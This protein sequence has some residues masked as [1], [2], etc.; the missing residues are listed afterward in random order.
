M[1]K[2]DKCL[3]ALFQK[4]NMINDDYMKEVEAYIK[5]TESCGGKTPIHPGLGKS[6]PTKME[7]LDKDN[8]TKEEK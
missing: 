5:V 8:P 6:N 2:S 1:I 4:R 3:Y 7:I